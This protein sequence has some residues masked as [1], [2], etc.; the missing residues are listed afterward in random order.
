MAWCRPAQAVFG[1]VLVTLVVW[2]IVDA[3]QPWRVAVLAGSV[4]SVLFVGRRWPYLAVLAGFVGLVAMEPLV[5]TEPENVFLLFLMIGCFIGGR[6]GSLVGQ[7][8]VGAVV[9]L[10]VSGTY[11][12]PGTSDEVSNVV[13]P[14]VLTAG[15][16]LLG[17]AIQLAARRER[18]AVSKAA[19][20]EAMRDE[21]LR[22][23]AVEER[24]RI[25]RELHDIVA[26]DITAV[27]LQAQVARRQAEAG[28]PVAADSLRDIEESARRAMTDVR[29]L[30]GVLRVA[31]A[32]VTAPVPGLELVGELVET[33]R[34]LGQRVE[35][36]EEGER[37]ALP[38]ALSQA[39]YRIV[40]EALT[41]ARR[42]GSGGT[43]RLHVGWGND[44]IS[45]EI[46]NPSKGSV[47]Q[48]GHGLTGISER[49]A[50][51]GGT[52]IAGPAGGQW[53]LDVC[54]PA[55]M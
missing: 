4:A 15:P 33:S 1:V 2:A 24:L 37:R 36:V 12:D 31:D 38:P 48:A 7:P 9:L 43:T 25:A 54:L 17:L 23:A 10:F 18:T 45:L 47:G 32:A 34:Q 6:F 46:T 28:R 27:S 41:N 35:V 20:L 26:H 44:A 5:G 51:F 3:T 13:F 30:L 52:A 40:Q 42:H 8:W 21:E 16:W 22:R 29:R 49:A 14:L 11:L 50:M 53:R 19:L 39:A 55:R